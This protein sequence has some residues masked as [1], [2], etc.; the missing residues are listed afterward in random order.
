MRIDAHHHLWKREQ[1]AP[2]D[3]GWLARPGNERI[4]RDFLPEDLGPHLQ[5]CGLDG[6]IC[7]QTQH[8]LGENRWALNLAQQHDW[9]LGVVGWVDLTSTDCESQLLEF[10]DQSKFVGIRHVVQDEPDDFLLRP[11]VLRGL[12]VLENHDVPFDLLVYARQ[13]KHAAPLAQT[14]P[15]L[16]IVLNHLGKPRIRDGAFD[17]WLKDFRVIANC[18]NVVCKLSGLIT[19]ADHSR[20]EIDDLRRYVDA[21]LD[22]FGPERLLFGSDWPVC[23]L[24]GEYERVYTAATELTAALSDA[25]RAAIFGINATRVYGLSTKR[26]VA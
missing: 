8:H 9:M 3:Y 20:W 10:K 24:A 1:P 23:E 22:C 15:K 19:E 13:L 7:V 26:P 12:R 14:L 25:E 2:F 16:R 4:D 11:D 5:A 6:A 17:G 18:P 21:A